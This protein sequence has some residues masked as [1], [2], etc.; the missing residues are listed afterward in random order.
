MQR[1]PTRLTPE[2]AVFALVSFEGVDRYSQAGGL[3][4]RVTGLA[5]T[6]AQLGFETHLFFIGDPGLPGRERIDGGRLI[7]HRWAQW[8]SAHHP[9]GVYDGEEGKRRDLT[10]SLPG[11]LMAEVIAPALARGRIPVVLSEEWQTAEFASLLAE[12]LRAAGLR[13]DTILFWNANNPYSFERIDWPR[14]TAT[15]TLTTVSRYMR[16][17]MRAWGADALVVP[18]GIP[19]RLVRRAGREGAARLRAG[20]AGQRFFFKMARWERE[21]GWDQA[22]DAVAVLRERGHPVTLVA[23]SGGPAGA[24]GG[25]A[26]AAS[27]RGLRAIELADPGG[28]PAQLDV[29][30][31]TE[32]DVV[33]LRFG[34]SEALARVLFAGADGVLANSVSEPFGL[35][36][37]EAMAA[38]GVVFTG[39]TGE[40]YAIPDHNALVLGTLDPREIADRAQDL[41]GRPAQSRRL[42]H[43]ARSTARRYTWE[44]VTRLLISHLEREARRRNLLPHLGD[45]ERAPDLPSPSGEHDR[46]A[47]CAGPLAHER[48]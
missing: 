17:I 4:I 44:A 10:A 6:L 23:R 46:Q 30:G 22:L 18:N 33:S 24:G 29:I 11:Y 12:R 21:K 20:L 28:L 35:V 38:G 36:G 7:L 45:G 37:L 2:N 27:R 40:D 5:H 13:D 26:S 41:E 9:Q 3:G 1:G 32:A 19:R 34:V 15:N 31:C 8:I 43:A 47:R 39:G 48:A 42:R 25:V 16:A 14:L